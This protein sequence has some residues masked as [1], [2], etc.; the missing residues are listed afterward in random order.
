MILT[1]NKQTNKQQ[2][3]IFFVLGIGRTVG[4]TIRKSLQQQ[5]SYL[6]T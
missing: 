3:K 5:K 2:Q 4:R 6:Q 1:I